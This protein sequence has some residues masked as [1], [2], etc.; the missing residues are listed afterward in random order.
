MPAMASGMES[1]LAKQP[2]RLSELK[3][4]EIFSAA[5]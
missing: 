2:P 5:R 1:S 3:K 4:A